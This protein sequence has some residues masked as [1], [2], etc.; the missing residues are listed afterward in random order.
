MNSS[1]TDRS[2]RTSRSEPE[3]VFLVGV[4]FV[5]RSL[6]RREKTSRA[7]EGGAADVDETP[8]SRPRQQ[9]PGKVP[10]S[11]RAARSVADT[12]LHATDTEPRS[13]SADESMAELRE[14]ARSAG[15][16]IAG[17]FHQRRQRPDSATLIG[18]GKVE[19]L[20]GAVASVAPDLVIF[21]HE[22]TPSQ[23]RNLERELHIRVIDR[24]QLILDIFARHARTREGQLQVELAQLEYMLPAARRTR[25]RNV[26]TRRRHRHPRTG[27]NPA[28]N[29]SPTHLPA[30]PPR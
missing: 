13:F 3:R 30:R 24:T 15:A 16:T 17:E 7:S 29:R 14:L 6:A 8:D 9:P 18:S 12:R 22:L 28:R 26:A 23:Q 11:A 20:N 19:E 10:A 27:R 25:R 5:S 2:W 4:E 1:S 21:D